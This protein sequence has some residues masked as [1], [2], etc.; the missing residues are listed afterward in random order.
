MQF[1]LDLISSAGFLILSGILVISILLLLIYKVSQKNNYLQKENKRLEKLSNNEVDIT[2]DK[3][4]LLKILTHDLKNPISALKG[5]AMLIQSDPS[6]IES[7]KE[8]S[9]MIIEAADEVTERLGQFLNMQE[10][11]DVKYEL[12]KSQ[13]DIAKL[14]EKIVEINRPQATAKQQVLI[15][16]KINDSDFVIDAD[17]QKLMAAIDNIVNNAIKYSP[18]SKDITI[19]LGKNNKKVLIEVKDEGP[20][21]SEEDME[22]AFGKFKRLSAR[23]TGGELSSGLGLF[24]VKR[25]IE[26]HNGK[27]WIKSIEGTGSSFYIEV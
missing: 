25:I 9:K 3:N 4:E 24:I 21:F 18:L 23:P 20:G 27:V 10:V 1:L 7:T 26:L 19:K 22:L 11:E 6:D 2:E 13:V 16:Q 12:N 5:S 15:Y 14:M 17:E 8:L